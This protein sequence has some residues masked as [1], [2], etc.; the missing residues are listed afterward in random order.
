MKVLNLVDSWLY[1]SF[2]EDGSGGVGRARG[3][4]WESRYGNV[5]GWAATL[6]EVTTFAFVCP[7][8]APTNGN[9]RRLRHMNEGPGPAQLYGVLPNDR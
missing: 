9:A 4:G 5:W 3:H 1:P 7:S 2:F 6:K 8:G